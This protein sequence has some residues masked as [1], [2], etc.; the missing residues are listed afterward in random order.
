VDGLC[1]TKS[2]GVALVVH[3]VSYQD[4]QPTWSWSTTVTDDG[5]HAIARSRFALQCIMW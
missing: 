5:W 3:A 4:F 2:E 1:A